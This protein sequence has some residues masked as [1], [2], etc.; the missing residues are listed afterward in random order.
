MGPN[1]LFEGRKRIRHGI[2][3]IPLINIVFLLLI[4]F[5]LSGTLVTPDKFDIELPESGQGHSHESMPIVV[6][7]HADG[8]IAVNNMPI[9][10]NDLAKTLES[11][12]NAGV[13]PKLMI[14]AD[15]SANT[16]DVIAVLRH[17]KISGIETIALATQTSTL[18]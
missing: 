2:N 4:F 16:A 1:I 9:L 7:I 8:T 5:M 13:D 17:A 14:R 15:A 12:I 18:P 11:D 10:L 6:L 3:L